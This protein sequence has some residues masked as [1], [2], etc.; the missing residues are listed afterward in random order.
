MIKEIML[1]EISETVESGDVIEIFVRVGDFIDVEQPLAQLETDKATFDVPSPA[2]GKVV[3]IAI[4]PGQKVNVGQLLLKVDTEAAPGAARTEQTTTA[5]RPAPQEP[6]KK[7]TE[8]ENSVVS[9]K[10]AGAASAIPVVRQGAEKPGLE[11]AQVAG[12]VS[13]ERRSEGDTTPRPVGA[14]AEKSLPDFS[15][16]GPIERKAITA[17]RKKIAETLS[18]TWATVPQVTQYDQA[19]I[20]AMEQFRKH[21][22]LQVNDAGGKLTITAIVLKAVALVLRE[23]PNFNASFDAQTNEII[24]KKYC[25]LC[26]AVD[27][28]RGLLVPVLRDVDKKSLLQV[29]VEVTALAERTKQRQVTPEE[30]VGGNFTVTNLGGLGGGPFA[31]IIYWPQT[32]ILGVARAAKQPVC[33][34]DRVRPR[35]IVPL[36]LSYDH[37]VID[38]AEGVRFLRRIVELLENPFVLA[39]Q[40]NPTPQG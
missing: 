9:Q 29:A 35:L 33:I 7:Q 15:L 25:H 30:M 17:T 6:E 26:V 10:K 11:A 19:D 32:A 36:S 22:S 18:Y 21:Y 14:A 24:Y 4:E 34:D 39:L 16:W 37:R 28:D 27:T 1:P 2:K 13:G 12:A 40:E 38:G 23:F 5:G 31:P 3:E 20:T 8:G